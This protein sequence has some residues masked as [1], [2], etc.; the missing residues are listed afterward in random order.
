MA[1]QTLV[2]R[3]YISKL[4]ALFVGFLCLV[5]AYNHNSSS[6]YIFKGEAYGTT[7]SLTTTKYLNDSHKIVIKDIIKKIDYV[8]SNYKEDS[9]IAK[10]N[11]L[12]NSTDIKV[13]NDLF[14]ILEIAN[15]ISALTNNSYDIKLG[16]YSSSL[17]FSPTFNKDLSTHGTSFFLLNK[18]NQ[19]LNK[20]GD[21]WFDLSSIAKG[22]AVDKIVTYLELNNFNNFIVEIGG[23]L[24]VKGYSHNDNWLLAI[25]DPRL[26]TQKPG[27]L[28]T[29]K[30]GKKI[31]IATSGE[32]RNYTFDKTGKR[33]THTLNPITKKSILNDSL[34]VTVVSKVS[35]AHA[36][37]LA[38]AFNVMSTNNAIKVAND[39][40]IAAMFIMQEADKLEFRYTDAWYYSEYE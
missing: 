22:Y 5:I 15:N 28:I 24:T 21:F 30:D 2:K 39:N 3:S 40:E 8:A 17:G 4:I 1:N 27:K 19:T 34:S 20:N 23:E 36:D 7:W 29:N 33:I 26:L 9:E 35:A 10:I 32:Y 31:S 16:K 37:A 12:P 13:S 6:T 38:T 11:S 25:Q 18:T 14:K